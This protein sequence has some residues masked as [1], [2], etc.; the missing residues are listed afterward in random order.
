METKPL[1]YDEWTLEYI[2]NQKQEKVERQKDIVDTLRNCSCCCVW[3]LPSTVTSY[4]YK[5]THE[6]ALHTLRHKFTSWFRYT[7]I[8]LWLCVCVCVVVVVFVIVFLVTCASSTFKWFTSCILCRVLKSFIS[9]LFSNLSCAHSFRWRED[10]MKKDK[11]R[12]ASTPHTELVELSIFCWLFEYI[13]CTLYA[14]Y[15]Q[16]HTHT[17]TTTQTHIHNSS[18]LSSVVFSFSLSGRHHS[19]HWCLV[20]YVHAVLTHPCHTKVNVRWNYVL[21]VDISIS[22]SF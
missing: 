9:L 4:R 20:C 12:H 15:T 16:T 1:I 5:Y 22:I 17:R 2:D 18:L 6:H 8:F 7:S 19:R 21:E 14:H 10:A 11:M 3:V 13:E